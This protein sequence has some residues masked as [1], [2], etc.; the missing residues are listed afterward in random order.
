[1]IH[2]SSRLARAL[3]I[4]TGM[5]AFVACGVP[6]DAPL[7]AGRDDS[8]TSRA[9]VVT[10]AAATPTAPP[11]V[12]PT[13]AATPTMVVGAYIRH[14]ALQGG[15]A[16]GRIDGDIRVKYTDAPPVISLEEAQQ[17][18]LD[19]GYTYALSLKDGAR[20]LTLDG[21]YGLAT[22]GMEAD[23]SGLH[24][25][26]PDGGA[27][28]Y[29]TECAGWAGPCPMP[30]AICKNGACVDT[31]RRLGP[32]RNRPYWFLDYGGFHVERQGCAGCPIQIFT[33]A[34]IAVDA[35]ER[36]VLMG[37]AYT[38]QTPEAQP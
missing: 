15:N 20:Q 33:N 12:S 21:V 14:P 30:I 25:Y 17:I 16:G 4:V 27:Q 34:V 36:M 26:T 11:T 31:G 10:R 37:Y 7:G 3:L 35:Q 22:I 2:V 13:P 19:T 29:P 5:G 28:P 6:D 1:M 8:P 38:A 23:T 24:A 18:A 9:P 32:I